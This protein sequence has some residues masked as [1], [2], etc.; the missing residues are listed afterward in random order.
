MKLVT[1]SPFYFIMLFISNLKNTKGKI[2]I[3]YIRIPIKRDNQI[4]GEGL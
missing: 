4:K 2:C 1:T 3:L